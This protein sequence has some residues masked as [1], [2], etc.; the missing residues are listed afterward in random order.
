M[1][2]FL[3]IHNREGF[4]VERTLYPERWTVNTEQQYIHTERGDN[5]WPSV[6][7]ANQWAEP[8]KGVICFNIKVWGRAGWNS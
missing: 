2:R 6:R 1:A 4:S 8:E 7:E 3:Y 5:V